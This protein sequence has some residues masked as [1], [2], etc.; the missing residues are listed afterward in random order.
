MRRG[1]NITRNLINL[2]VEC[3]EPLENKK[4][5][6]KKVKVNQTMMAE[7]IQKKNLKVLS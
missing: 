1:D 3:Q 6:E 4:S 7:I 5:K 2:K